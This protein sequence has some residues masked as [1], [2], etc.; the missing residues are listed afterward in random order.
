MG[1]LS[2]TNRNTLFKIPHKGQIYQ[3]M[4]TISFV[5]S[6][7]LVMVLLNSIDIFTTITHHSL[8]LHLADR[9]IDSTRFYTRIELEFKKQNGSS[10]ASHRALDFSKVLSEY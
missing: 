5:E 6:P 8:Y 9:E 7:K 4:F 10:S 2:D 1:N 3:N